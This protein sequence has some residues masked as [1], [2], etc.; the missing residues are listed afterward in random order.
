M[1][2]NL[3]RDGL[4]AAELHTLEERVLPTARAWLRIPGLAHHGVQTLQAWGE[5]LID[6]HGKPYAVSA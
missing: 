6:D 1:T 4:T 2:P 3:T 5:P